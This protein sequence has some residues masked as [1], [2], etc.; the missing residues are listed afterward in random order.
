M[1]CKKCNGTGW[2]RVGD[3]IP[4]GALHK[5][6]TFGDDYVLCDCQTND[7]MWH[8][9]RDMLCTCAR[10]DGIADPNCEIC[11]GSGVQQAD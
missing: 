2:E 6:M 10:K 5:G 1:S 9:V 8:H 4:T 7:P 3:T 11:S